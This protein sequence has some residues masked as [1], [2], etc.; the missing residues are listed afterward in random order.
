MNESSRDHNP[1]INGEEKEETTDKCEANSWASDEEPKPLQPIQKL[2]PEFSKM[3]MQKPFTEHHTPA[4]TLELL[5]KQPVCFTSAD[6][7]D[8]DSLS[9]EDSIQ[10]C[11]E[12]P[13][14]SKIDLGSIY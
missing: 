9:L 8:F 11:V 4:E 5:P 6:H 2:Q 1:L 7:E 12:S 14:K 3:R 10:L 13:I